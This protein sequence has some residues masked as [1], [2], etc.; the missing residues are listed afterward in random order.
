MT[1]T[2]GQLV[3]HKP[4]VALG[5]GRV[6]YVQTIAGV[7]QVGVVWS[8]AAQHSQHTLEELEVL[9]PLPER[10]RDV[11]PATLVPF[12]LRVLAR[13]FEARHSLTGELSNQPFQ[14]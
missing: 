11:G 2:N 5:Q 8:A 3:E 14:M 1:L 10:L 13:W 6:L 4:D 7:T 9:R 12:Q